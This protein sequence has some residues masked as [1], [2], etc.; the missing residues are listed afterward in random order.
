MARL[1]GYDYSL[2]GA[3][4]ITV[5]IH[6]RNQKLFGD[7]VG[8]IIVQNDYGNIVRK[9]WNDSPSHYP[10]IRLDEFIVMPNHIHGIIVIRA[11]ASKQINAIRQHGIEKIWQRNYYDHIIRDGKSRYAIC[12]Y[13]KNNPAN[14][15]TGSEHHLDNEID[16]SD[17]MGGALDAAGTPISF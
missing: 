16:I 3:Y 1:R 6:D 14:W 17:R 5:C 13:I 10:R 7:V 15:T 4:F 12:Q 8:G 11:S 2:P 9:C